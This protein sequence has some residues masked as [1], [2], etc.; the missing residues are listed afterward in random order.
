MS[1]G[2]R[3][4]LPPRRWEVPLDRRHLRR[5]RVVHDRVERLDALFLKAEPTSTG[6]RRRRASRDGSRGGSPRGR[7]LLVDELLHQTRRDRRASRRARGARPPRPLGTRRDVRVLPLLAHVA[8]PVMGVHVHEV[9]HAVEVGLVPQ[10]LEDERVAWRRS[11]II[12][13]VRSKLAPV[14]SI[15]LMKQIRDAVAV[16]LAPD[17]LA[18]RLDT[19]DGVEDRDGAVED[20]E[21]PLHLDREVDVAG[22][23]D[24]VDPVA[25]PLARGRGRVIVIPRARS[26]TIQSICAVPSWTSPIL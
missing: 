25:L 13:T 18:L 9:D 24:D 10:E 14:R 22:R 8:L 19:G 20:A 16:G 5:R 7:L 2:A 23:V 12:S 6:R 11:M 26:W 17:G 3:S 1:S 21:R 15:L 4:T